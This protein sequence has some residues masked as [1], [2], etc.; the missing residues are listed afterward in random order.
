MKLPRTTA[1]KGF[2]LIELLVVIAIIAILA[3]MLLPALSHAKTESL[4]A[5]CLSN[6]KQLEIAWY[7]Y[8]GDNR[9]TLAY[10]FD[11][12]DFGPYMPPGTAS[13]PPGTPSWCEGWLDWSS[14]P[15]NTNT[16]YLLSP[17]ASLLGSYVGNQPQI[18]ACPADVYA[19]PPQ[20]SLGWPSR[21][22]SVTM[23]G[24]IGNG[25]KWSFGW[26]LTNPI[27]KMG[28]FSL[29][30]PAMSW[31]MMDEHPDWMDDSI[32]YVNPAE[33]DGLGEFTEVPGSFHN[34]A[35]AINFA[36]GHAEIHKWRDTRILLPVKYEYHPESIDISGTPSPDLAWM[37]QRTPYK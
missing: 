34:N 1:P 33:S 24:N 16:L 28:D 26:T 22:R 17:L 37:A 27:V 9:D 4:S 8:A 18:Y 2:T 25:E 3:G 31:L 5:K 35:C 10:N 36:D 12:H 14:A 23:D 6:K 19:S 7:M 32:L 30:G 21:C 29:P 20:R 15:V 11:Y 13:S